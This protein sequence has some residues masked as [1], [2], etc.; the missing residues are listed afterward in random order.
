[1][2]PAEP[3][4]CISRRISWAL[5]RGI[6]RRGQIRAITISLPMMVQ[7][8]DT[9]VLILGRPAPRPSEVSKRLHDPEDDIHRIARRGNGLDAEGPTLVAASAGDV[10]GCAAEGDEVEEGEEEH[11]DAEEE[12]GEGEGDVVVGEGGGGFEGVGGEEDC[13]EEVLEEGE[14]DDAFDADEFGEGFVRA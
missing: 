8:L 6:R 10:I 12:V 7:R 1:M 9:D 13:E 2:I 4:L 11:F 14:E 5:V 3:T